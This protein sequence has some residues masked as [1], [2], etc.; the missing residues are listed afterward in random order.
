MYTITQLAEKI[1]AELTGDGS[2]EIVAVA[3]A[4]VAGSDN[5]TFISSDKYL[6]Q[7]VNSKAGAVIIKQQVDGF[8]GAQLI[9]DNVDIALVGTLKLLAPPLKPQAPGISE[10]AVIG[11][12]VTIAEG[13]SIGSHV[14]ICDG[15][16][17]GANTIIGPGSF[18]GQETIIGNNTRIDANVTIH[19]QC[20][21]GSNAYT[22]QWRSNN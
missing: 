21:I 18:I 19:H 5:V 10:S 4:E 16:Q 13:A 20:R 17:I 3:G 12:N 7:L 11:D 2:A 22:A 8:S 9:V 15:V 6:P 14:T 1:G